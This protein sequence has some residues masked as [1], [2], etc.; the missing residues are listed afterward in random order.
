MIASFERYPP[1]SL[2]SGTRPRSTKVTEE[3][4][5]GEANKKGLWDFLFALTVVD[6]ACY[7]LHKHE[8]RWSGERTTYTNQRCPGSF[9]GT[10]LFDVR[11]A[12][13]YGGVSC[14]VTDDE[15]LFLE[16]L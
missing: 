12:E 1:A 14:V 10:T 2:P 7:L 3:R 16:S 8:V 13:R 6:V 4:V 15:I 9:C 11:E 5:G